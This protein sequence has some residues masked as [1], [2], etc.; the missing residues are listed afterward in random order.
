MYAQVCTC[1]DIAYT[2]EKFGRY[3]INPGIDHL[4][5]YQEGNAISIEDY[6]KSDQLQLIGYT[7]SD[8]AV[9]IDNR[10][11]TSCYIFLIVGRWWI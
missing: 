8:Y 5:D 9:C 11:S 10:K 1:S 3:L 4:K 7:D 6:M 2:I